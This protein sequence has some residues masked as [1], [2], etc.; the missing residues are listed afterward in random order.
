[1]I[2]AVIRFA[3]NK[4]KL[5]HIFLIFL[6]LMGAF[7]YINV[8]KEIFPPTNLDAISVR[9]A[10]SGA[11]PSILDNLAVSPIEDELKNL[12]DIELVES[13]IKT[14]MFTIKAT[15][16]DDSNID[17]TLS[18]IKDIIQKIKRDL[19]S[20]MVE[21]T[22]KKIKNTFPLV[23][24]AISSNDK[25]ERLLKVADELKKELSSIKDLSDINIRGDADK[26]LVFTIDSKKIEALGLNHQLVVQAISNLSNTFP[27]G[28]IEQKGE[29]LFLNTQSGFKSIQKLKNTLIKVNGK[30]VY[31]KDIAHIE[32]KLSDATE[33][34]HFNGT[35]NI[36]VNIN[37]AKS[38]NA[39]ALVKKIKKI[40][41]KY[42][43]KYPQYVLEVYSDSS[44]WIRNRLNTVISNILFGLIL[45]SLSIYIFINGRIA[46][47]VALGIP[48]SFIIGL[49][50][51]EYL[52]Y[53]LNMLSLLGALIALGML[54]DEAIV[55]AENIQRHIEE[56]V[57]PKEA[58]IKG[59]TE[60]FPAVLTA[61]ATTIF[62]FLP[63]LIMSGE[64]GVFMKILPIMITILL[65]SSLFEAFFFLPLHS[66]EFLRKD[67]KAKKS[68][69][70]WDRLK[71][72]Y[73]N[74]LSKLISKPKLS[75]ALF[76]LITLGGTIILFKASKFQLFPEFDTTQIYIK[77]SVNKNFRLEETQELVSKVEKVLLQKLDKKDVASITSI[78][79]L[80]INNKFK[81][82]IS[83]NYFHIFVN[84][85]ERAPEGFYNTFINP[86]FSPEYDDKDMIREL[87]ANELAKDIKEITKLF[88]KDKDF[89]EFDVIVPSA[90][91]VKSDIEISLIGETK[92]VKQALLKLQKEIEDTKG[93]YNIANDMREG[94]KEVKFKINP[95]GESLGIT[96]KYLANIL[97]PMYLKLEISNMYLNGKLIKVK[98]EDINKD[99]LSS[100][101]T[102]F[103]PLPNSP[104]KVL[105]K[106]IAEFKI[107]SSFSTIYK[108]DGFVIWT[109][110]GSLDK[111]LLT[112][113]E[114]MQKLK[115]IFKEI[116][117]NGIVLKIKGEQK[118]NQKVKK[119]MSQ[120]GLIALFLIFI[121]LVWMF[122]SIFL[123]LLVL[124]TI[125]LSV[126]GVL[127]GHLLMGL[128]LTMPGLVGIVGLSGVVVNDGII[129]IDFLKK[130]S[131][132]EEVLEFAAKRLRPIMLTSIT[133]ILG[134]STLIFFAS[135]QSVILQP[136]AVS[137]GY[138]LLW[139][140]V[141]NLFFL[142]LVFFVLKN[143][144]SQKNHKNMIQSLK[145]MIKDRYAKKNID[146]S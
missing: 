102:L 9:G 56:G 82:D 113:S 54:V 84:L 86:I 98:T 23:T 49:I 7:A 67:K 1:M 46:F 146:N 137:L 131:S 114:L 91:I 55:V 64:M 72:R 13:T 26:E 59:A 143:K 123:S 40:L 93:S 124:S 11:S 36:S 31:L 20:D 83:P 88:T 122:D 110:T 6:F 145:N 4:A 105:L 68:D 132:K 121:A 21:P 30:G 87:S 8:P 44:V 106:D 112:S 58:A 2:E 130:A 128:N 16:K 118:E 29:H 38:G 89:E 99:K 52:G 37:K 139:A 60:M 22:A 141:L 138:G 135:G 27:V 92:K 133:T 111:K 115:P 17:D 62:A 69:E 10:Y 18:D 61:T 12:S 66:F 50:A 80:K 78:S 35:Q 81:A 34:S 95:Y 24:I 5:N 119:E 19:P 51:L 142:P 53:S 129:M 97:R 96:E 144:N 101:N 25:K 104:Q 15:L 120:A 125:P 77:G 48:T 14:G 47:V 57:P 116:K 3:I 33:V 127:L 41:K 73:K 70:L 28:F 65:L 39:I 85:H 75:V 63:M 109:I 74:T 140:T 107:K 94:E 71:T 76:L 136:M 43:T 42:E 100:L 126:F 32:F 45:V 134:L 90:G 79:G 103:I 117:Q 108:E